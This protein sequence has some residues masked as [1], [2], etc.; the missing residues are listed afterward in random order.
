MFDSALPY[1]LDALKPLREKGYL[2]TYLANGTLVPS[3]VT[4]IGTGNSPLDLVKALSPRDYF[5]DAP[6]AQLNNATLATEWNVTLSPVAS[7]DYEVVVG[8]SGIGEI[9]EEQKANITRLVN[10][11]H[12]RGL[13]AR[14]WDTPG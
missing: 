7:T 1:I 6:L 3:A 11:A 12:S 14:F 8:Y 4:V 2:T 13:A 10:D 5:F 9:T